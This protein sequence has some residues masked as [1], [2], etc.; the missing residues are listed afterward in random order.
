MR[1]L[2]ILSIIFTVAFAQDRSVTITG[3]CLLEGELDHSG[4]EI[5]FE[6]VS[7]SAE[8][9]TFTTDENGEYAAGLPEGIY[10]ITFLHDGFIPVTLPGEINFF[11]DDELEL[12]ELLVGTV[13]E[14]SGTLD[15]NQYWTDNFQYRVTG[16][17]TLNSG[18]TLSIDPGVSVLFM[19]EYEFIINGAFYANGAEGDSI[20][21]TSG[22]PVKDRG[23][24]K[25]LYFDYADSTSFLNYVVVEYGG[26]SENSENNANIKTYHS[27]LFINNSDIHLSNNSGLCGNYDELTLNNSLVNNNIYYGVYL[28]YNSS[29]ADISG[30]EIYNNSN[31][32][33]YL[34]S[35]TADISGN[36]I[37]N[38]SNYGVYLNNNSTTDISGNEIHNNGSR[39]VYVRWYSTADISGN[40]IHNNSSNGVI[41]VLYSTAD[42]SGNEIHNN[43]SNGVVVDNS[44]ADI[45]GN[46]IHNNGSNG[47]NLYD[48]STADISG[49]D[50]HNNS[51]YGVY[52]NISTADI[53]NNILWANGTCLQIQSEGSSIGYNCFY[54]NGGLYTNSS[55]YYPSAFGEVMTVNANGD[56]TDTWSNLFMDPMLIDIENGDY[57][58]Q[59]GSPVIDA[60]DPN[61]TDPDGSI[62]D[63]GMLYYDWGTQAPTITSISADNQVGTFPLIVQFSAL[64]EG[65]VTSYS[66]QFG[67]GG[68][69][70]NSNPV[71]MYSTPGTYSVSL[72]VEGPG[73]SASLLDQDLI[74]VN[75]QMSP[76]VA[77]FS[78]NVTTGLVPLEV[79]FS[80]MSQNQVDS[81]LWNF[82]DGNESMDENPSH[83]YQ[84]AGQYSVSLVVSGPYGED[85]LL[86]TDYVTVL[87]PEAVVASFDVVSTSGIAPFTVTFNNTSIGTVDS[88][89][90]DFG[91]GE[92]SDSESPTHTYMD[93][94]HYV[95]TLTVN[96]MINSDSYSQDIFAQS[97]AP[98]IDSVSDVPA[99]QGGRV[100]V[101]FTS[102]AYDTDAPNRT[103]QYSVERFDDGVWVNVGSGP[104]YGAMDYTFE[105][106]TLSDSTSTN[107]ATS[108][109]RVIAAMDEGIWI[110]DSLSG[111]SLDNLAPGAPGGLT[112]IY[113]GLAVTLSWSSNQESDIGYYNV[114]RNNEIL[115]N[116]DEASYLDA[117]IEDGQDY[118]Y[119]I[120]AVDIHENESSESESVLIHIASLGDVNSNGL[121]DIVDIVL[122]VQVILGNNENPD[123]IAASDLN[124][125]GIIDILDIVLLVNI[126][127]QD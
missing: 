39:G 127:L 68:T 69:S 112:A 105:V 18:D 65:P 44:T 88:Y 94:G 90:W 50:I 64:T 114:Y 28:L 59:E 31:Y 20:R 107:D 6:A 126:I 92:T 43:G 30:N 58:P 45:S 99:D 7:G 9:N 55:D 75:E 51:D 115:F 26:G 86:I 77:N 73:G 24:W 35:S 62:S 60:G 101:M 71:H 70:S 124:S 11:D 22:R 93:V 15:G 32:G 125:D 46:E 36:E 87:E 72:T 119:H 98:I 47:V 57:N 48:F 109:F 12:V 16:D 117:D 116:T 89:S 33:V 49:N 4:T 3:T 56:S 67:D 13:Q 63:I 108:F 10:V 96:G 97:A 123:E 103:E 74:T 21:F 76:P 29:T 25:W 53:R 2:F 118:Q 80:N 66:W 85:T 91:D 17:L 78:S 110:S 83:T 84:E 5:L 38:N 27:T 37:Y 40:E 41:V 42:I 23:D 122:M 120:T 104:A 8:T 61:F 106:N 102:S 79:Q 1:K 95:A 113:E 82:G 14:V 121:I 100:Y 19:G 34:N 111:Q 52:L 81:Y 54:D